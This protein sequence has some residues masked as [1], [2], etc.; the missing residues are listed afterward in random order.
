MAKIFKKEEAS[1]VW[2]DDPNYKK[3]PMVTIRLNQFFNGIFEQ[4][5]ALYMPVEESA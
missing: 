2:T 4:L 3:S 1:I 5:D